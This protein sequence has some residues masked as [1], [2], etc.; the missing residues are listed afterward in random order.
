MYCGGKPI[1]LS[2]VNGSLGSGAGAKWVWYPNSSLTGSVGTGSPNTLTAPTQTT[3]YYVRGEGP[4]GSSTAVAKL[5]SIR[6]DPQLASGPQ[7]Y[8]T[9]CDGSSPNWIS[10]TCTPSSG[11]SV[12]SVQWHAAFSENAAKAQTDAIDWTVD[13]AHKYFSGQN[14]LTLM[15]A[16]QSTVWVWCTI[17][18]T[19]DRT[20]NSNYANLHVSYIDDN[21]VCQ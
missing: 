1:S 13:G 18:D 4:C 21:G 19:C 11:T 12:K 15:V 8:A 17:T 5:V 3:T 16:T 10:F 2:V 20:V 6:P 14:G 9:A 7:D